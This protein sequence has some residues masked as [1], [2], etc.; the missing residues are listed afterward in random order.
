MSSSQNDFGF[1]NRTI[2]GPTDIVSCAKDFAVLTN[3]FSAMIVG[4]SNDHWGGIVWN[5]DTQQLLIGTGDF[6]MTPT[7][8]ITI[9][10]GSSSAIIPN[11]S[12]SGD[13]NM[14]GHSILNVLNINGS[15]STIGILKGLNMSTNNITNAT[16]IQTTDITSNGV[17]LSVQDNINMNSHDIQS[18]NAIQINTSNGAGDIQLHS[19]GGSAQTN[20]LSKPSG[21]LIVNNLSTSKTLSVGVPLFA[22]ASGASSPQS[23]V[24]SHSLTF[25]SL[26]Q[27]GTVIANGW[28]KTSNLILTYNGTNSQRAF[29]QISM[30]LTGSTVTLDTVDIA[31]FINPVINGSNEITGQSDF[32]QLSKTTISNVGY[33]CLSGVGTTTNAINTN[34]T[35]AIAIRNNTNTDAITVQYVNTVIQMVSTGADTA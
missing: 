25:T 35:F 12:F 11:P 10:W 29:F 20:L 24:I 15:A 3:E 22:F 31:V 14:N 9:D 18:C 27:F 5:P 6:S 26:Q 8:A 4:G 23:V 2:G 13:L 32:I 30:G 16:S 33:S 17:G 21:N 7:A 34:D 19:Q 28:T 1:Q